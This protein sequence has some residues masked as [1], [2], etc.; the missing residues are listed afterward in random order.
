M[1]GTLIGYRLQII[2]YVML[3][4]LFMLNKKALIFVDKSNEFYLSVYIIS[5]YFVLAGLV[6]VPIGRLATYFNVFVIFLLGDVLQCFSLRARPLV[7]WLV[8]SCLIIWFALN[9]YFY[10]DILPYESIIAWSS[11]F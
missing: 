5:L 6:S 1:G 2:V 11:T 8:I 7:G 3:L 10:G 4:M 9:A